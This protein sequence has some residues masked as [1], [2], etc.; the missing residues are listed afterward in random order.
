[1]SIRPA[2]GADRDAV[3]ALLR[4]SRLPL[5][6]L[7]PDLQGFVV[8]DEGESIVGCAGVE[9]YGADGLLRSVAIHQDARG[10]GLGQQLVEAAMAD[11]WQRGLATLYLLTTTA[12]R[13]FP[14]LGF[15]AISR[16][17]VSP[18]VQA[19]VEFASAC[20]ASAIVMR[21]PPAPVPHHT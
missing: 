19:S 15:Q 1:M 17:Q 9:A 14:R 4:L 10:R 13:W 2:T 12:D 3:E 8:A 18:A 16:D 5:D 6:G 20:P 11:A 21:R 7:A